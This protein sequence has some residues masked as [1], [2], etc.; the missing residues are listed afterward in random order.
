MQRRIELTRYR[1]ELLLVGVYML[2]CSSQK[3][4]T[5]GG[6]GENLG[7][8]HH[9][10]SL[11]SHII[12][13]SN[14]NIK[15]VVDLREKEACAEGISGP[16]QKK[17]P[18]S[19]KVFLNDGLGCF[20]G[21]PNA[22]RAHSKEDSPRG[23]HLG[24]FSFEKQALLASPRDGSVSCNVGNSLKVSLLRILSSSLHVL[25]PHLSPD[26]KLGC[27]CERS[28]PLASF[29]EKL[30]SSLGAL[31]RGQKS[32]FKRESSLGRR[33]FSWEV[34]ARA[35]PLWRDQGSQKLEGRR[36]RQREF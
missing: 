36:R 5:R 20:E 18:S 11:V 14:G 25:K 7:N 35:Y 16:S 30:R 31:L 4:R 24:P 1:S 19:S 13:N 3:L 33:R 15:R 6:A 27:R 22:S 8:N 9:P 17:S 32:V 23:L 29:L 10:L 34:R 28:L 26:R 12:S 21:E 2:K